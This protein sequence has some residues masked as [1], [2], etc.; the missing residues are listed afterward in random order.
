MRFSFPHGHAFPG[1][2]VRVED[3]EAT[4]GMCVV[5]FGDG[6]AMIGEWHPDGMT[7]F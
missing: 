5:E 7:S 3:A 1:G 2:Q 4:E 6:I